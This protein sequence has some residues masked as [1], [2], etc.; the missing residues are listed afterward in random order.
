MAVANKA[1]DNK[2]AQNNTVFMAAHGICL[3]KSCKSNN[4]TMQSTV[5]SLNLALSQQCGGTKSKLSKNVLALQCAAFILSGCVCTLDGCACS[6]GVLTATIAACFAFVDIV[7]VS[8]RKAF[9]PQFIHRIVSSSLRCLC[10]LYY[11]LY[12]FTRGFPH[13]MPWIDDDF[14]WRSTI[15]GSS[16]ANL[17]SFALHSDWWTR[18]IGGLG[19]LLLVHVSGDT[20]THEAQDISLL[21]WMCCRGYF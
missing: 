18:S 17:F 4:R 3:D 12:R 6:C 14:N 21:V 9:R 20:K 1:S 15:L 2:E 11:T 10:A 16:D 13:C 8:A 5:E 7:C 19:R